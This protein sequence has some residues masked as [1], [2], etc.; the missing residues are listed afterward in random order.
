M[1]PGSAAAT[2]TMPPVP[3]LKSLTKKLSPPSVRLSP[4]MKPPCVD[5]A[6]WTSPRVI[7]MAPASTRTLPPAGR[8]I[9]PKANA[10]P[11]LMSTCTG[12][13]FER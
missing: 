13:S 12:C 3:L 1:S 9:S 11:E 7:A 6:I 4:F 2:P 5:V 8:V 10:G